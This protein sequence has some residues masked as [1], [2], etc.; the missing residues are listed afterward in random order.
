MNQSPALIAALV[1]A[2][3]LTACGSQDAGSERRASSSK[4]PAT[5]VLLI[6][7]DTLRADAVGVYGQ[8]R[9]VTPHIDAFAHEGIVFENSVSSSPST[10]PSHASIFTGR[11][12]YSHGVRSNANYALGDSELTLAE[13]LKAQG[14][15]TRAEVAS[16]VITMRTRLDQG[17][18]SFHDVESDDVEL[19]DVRIQSGYEES[20]KVLKTRSGSDI[21]RHGIRFLET[22]KAEEGP[23]FLWLHYYDPHFPHVPPPRF[24]ARFPKNHYLAS[25]AYADHSL[26]DVLTALVRLDLTESTLVVITSDHGEGLGDHGE[27]THSFFVYDSTMRI[28]LVMRGPGLARNRRIAS[29]VR[30]VDIAPTILDLLGLP[31][32]EGAQ[33]V[34]LRGLM[35]G[36]EAP[37]LIGYGES[38]E[39]FKLFGSP[40]LRFVRQG[41]WK[42]IHTT[43]PELYDLKSDPAE[44]DNAAAREPERT[45]ELRDALTELLRNTT[46]ADASAPEIDRQ[47]G[48]RLEALG[49]LMGPAPDPDELA[50]LA[51]GDPLEGYSAADDVRLYS[52]A[53]GAAAWGS[54]E[55]AVLQFRDLRTRHPQS[56]MLRQRLVEA[57]HKMGDGGGVSQDEVAELLAEAL[58]FDSEN[59]DLLLRLSDLSNRIGNP[60]QAVAALG[61]VLESDPCAGVSRSA[62][63]NLLHASG[64]HHQRFEVARLGV[65]RC[66]KLSTALN[67]MAWVLATSTVE[68]LRDGEQAIA[69]AQ[70]AL[71]ASDE[72][73]RPGFHDTLAAAYAETGDYERAVEIIADAIL[74]LKRLH[75]PEAVIDEFSSH[76]AQFEAGEPL[77][78]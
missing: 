23:F 53:R 6:T 35:D 17:F 50:S 59:A 8:S 43:P 3:A 34:S 58:E 56:A 72:E 32:F 9:V 16:E 42:Y 19:L 44:L 41:H 75:M 76:L 65:L 1:S 5:N 11:H 31:P 70:R 28:P 49:Y 74:Q 69:L 14:Y 57:L 22:A 37:S 62:L 55:K 4:T 78:E 60:A 12:P 36:S 39:A 64:Q 33:G 13:A 15:R 25:V 73:S 24:T 47:T 52:A 61:R 10:L 30:S 21:S 66:P 68:E 77:R 20:E 29:L 63:L 18:D 40:V 26:G 46:T 27:S 48:K 38:I 71:A 7:I 45:A 51:L 54:L 67:D 2:L